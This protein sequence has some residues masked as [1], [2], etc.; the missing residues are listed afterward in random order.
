MLSFRTYKGMRNC[1][2][3]DFHLLKGYIAGDETTGE[4]FYDPR[5]TTPGGPGRIG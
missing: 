2:W 5:S 4:I 1:R 3:L